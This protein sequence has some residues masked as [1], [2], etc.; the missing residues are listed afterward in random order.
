MPTPSTDK[1]VMKQ[2]PALTLLLL[3]VLS[4][5]V[6]AAWAAAAPSGSFG[7]SERTS[8]AAGRSG[9]ER[10]I[11]DRRPRP[12]DLLPDLQTA[13][14]D[15]AYVERRDGRRYLRFSNVL[16]NR[17]RGPFEIV[18]EPGDADSARRRASS[19]RIYR[20]ADGDRRFRRNVDRDLRLR[21][22]GSV[23]FHSDHDHWHFDAFAG[24]RL[25]DPATGRVVGSSRKVSFCLVD[26]S[27]VEPRLRFAP[28]EGHYQ[29]C[30][31]DR[32]QGIS[33]GWAD[34][35]GAGVGGQEIEITG[36]RNGRYRLVST[37]DPSNRVLESNELNNR[38]VLEVEIRGDEVARRRHA[39]RLAAFRTV[40]SGLDRPTE[41][42]LL[43]GGGALVAEQS[44]RV[45]LVDGAGRLEAEPLAQVAVTASAAA[46]EAGLLGL[47][48]DPQ[49]PRNRFVYLYRT[50][51]KEG[52][53]VRYRLRANGLHKEATILRDIVGA[54]THNQGRLCFGPDGGL[55]IAVGDATLPHLAQDRTSRNGKILRLGPQ[56]Y[57]GN[58]AARPQLYSLGHREPEGLDWHPA[59]RQLV[60]VEQG[61]EGQDELNLVRRGGNYGWP[62]VR[63]RR[64]EPRFSPAAHVLEDWAPS[65]AAFVPAG[66]AWAGDLLVATR[67]GRLVRLGLARGRVA[68]QKSLLNGELG[69]LTALAAGR[70]RSLYLLTR[71]RTARRRP[72]SRR[73]A[74]M[75]KSRLETALRELSHELAWPAVPNVAVDVLARLSAASAPAERKNTQPVICGRKEGGT[76]WQASITATP[77]SSWQAEGMPASG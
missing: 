39:P 69:P 44:G 20:D 14:I 68:E 71:A 3:L 1:R 9:G 58:A 62:E 59:S 21:P 34:R 64:G 52:T 63:G 35:Y 53:V 16:T 48:V 46:G 25:E 37:V 54:P 32:V 72:P 47:A 77:A 15:T 28:H 57:R 49:F 29:G 43:P 65:A 74:L 2:L 66:S 7:G 23:L 40:A 19:Q 8:L 30:N 6:L 67:R 42:A 31:A 13:P 51:G 4:A 45:R 60:V 75:D 22:A 33:P 36:L 10:V 12:G 27:E 24:F 50:R 73:G 11:G 26:M 70:A 38:A 5:V 17:G 56:Q 55:Y 41:V 61:S 18:T 76:K